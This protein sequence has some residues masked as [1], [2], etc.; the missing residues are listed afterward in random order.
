MLPPS[1]FILGITTKTDATLLFFPSS[2]AHGAGFFSLLTGLIL[3]QCSE[4]RR[5]G[6]N[7][8]LNRGLCRTVGNHSKYGLRGFFTALP[9]QTSLVNKQSGW[10]HI[11]GNLKFSTRASGAVEQS[12]VTP[13][14]PTGCGLQKERFLHWLQPWGLLLP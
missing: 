13:D 14:N 8:Q 5:G 3:L 6:T 12:G 11:S 2:G 1:P 9:F 4:D 7:K 10:R